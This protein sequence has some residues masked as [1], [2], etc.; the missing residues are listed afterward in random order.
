MN[1]KDMRW[2]R[3]VLL[4]LCGVTAANVFAANYYWK[5]DGTGGWSS[6]SRWAVGTPDGPEGAPTPGGK[7]ALRFNTVR[8]EITDDDAAFVSTLYEAVLNERAV[9]VLNMT[10]NVT[11]GLA[12]QGS[13][14]TVIKLN[15]NVVDM[16]ATRS[17]LQLRGGDI[18]VSNGVLKVGQQ[19]V[20]FPNTFHVWKPGVLELPDVSEYYAAAVAGDGTIRN[21]GSKN[22]QLRFIGERFT[23]LNDELKNL[24]VRPPYEFSGT[25]VGNSATG[26]TLG[27]VAG[28]KVT[29]GDNQYTW[30]PLEQSFTGTETI[31]ANLRTPRFHRGFFGVASIGQEVPAGRSS[32]G[33]YDKL[34]F[35]NDATTA[36]TESG[37]VYLGP[38]GVTTKRGM[39]IYYTKLGSTT[40]FDAGPNGGLTF[41]ADTSAIWSDL[42]SYQ[43]TVPY[44][45]T[46]RLVLRGSNTSEC[47]VQSSVRELTPTT[48]LA[49]VK[50]G[51]GAWHFKGTRSNTG[52]YFVEQGQLRFDDLDEQGR[53]S[54]LGTATFLYTNW[55]G[56][57]EHENYALPFAWMVGDGSCELDDDLATLAY[58]GA[59]T[60]A[61]GTRPLAVNGA[62]RVTGGASSLRLSGAFGAAAGVNTLVLGGTGTDNLFGDVTN[63]VGSVRVVKEESGTWRLSGDVRLGGGLEVRAG[64]VK[65]SNRFSWYRLNM[66]EPCGANSDNVWFGFRLFGLW[67]ADG[68]LLSASLQGKDV[69][70]RAGSLGV[71]ESALSIPNDK[72]ANNRAD[73]SWINGAFAYSSVADPLNPAAASLLRMRVTSA[74]A[75]NVRPCESDESTWVRGVIR[76]ADDTAPAACYDMRAEESFGNKDGTDAYELKAFGMDGSPDG[77]HWTELHSYS[78]FTSWGSPGVWYSTKTKTRTNADGFRLKVVTRDATKTVE[79]ASIRVDGNAELEIEPEAD[80]TVSGVSYD[81]AAGGGKITGRL[82]LAEGGTLAVSGTVPKG[83]VLNLPMDLSKVEGLDRVS[84]W[85]VRINGQTSVWTA[86]ATESGF[87]IQPPGLL[88]IVR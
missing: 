12:F 61:A 6:P 30:G 59:R 17:T 3:S 52:P 48:T 71:N 44:A 14:S 60:G 63:G 56:A 25:F 1:A 42:L 78:G 70:G 76:L 13:K 53:S 45:T 72:F 4:A 84:S 18:V 41:T 10:T 62:G 55:Y 46:G 34:S 40:V 58:T 28:A 39:D 69:N 64:K 49:F 7:D 32:L 47:V 27:L 22:L 80:V 86:S 51:T 31:D 85:S 67:D 21:G 26:G 15:D 37:F 19:Y 75:A 38:A 82:S 29:V 57:A 50:Q 81:V 87:A 73:R 83:R 79:I 54:A 65:I 68:N 35:F 5:A 23:A 16:S 11:L 43:R 24:L 66:K 9:I 77:I 20:P 88:L 2:F 33:E 36:D 8:A 74:T